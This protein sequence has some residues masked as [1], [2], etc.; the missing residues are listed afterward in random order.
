MLTKTQIQNAYLNS[1]IDSYPDANW[2]KRNEH[3]RWKE[4]EELIKYL[5]L[6]N[7]D[8]PA[9]ALPPVL[10]E[11]NQVWQQ[12]SEAFGRLCQALNLCSAENFS[13]PKNQ[14]VVNNREENAKEKARQ[15]AEIL[16]SYI[17]YFGGFDTSR[18]QYWSA[19]TYI[20]N[21]YS[22]DLNEL[23]EWLNWYGQLPKAQKSNAPKARL[24]NEVCGA[25]LA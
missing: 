13:D 14:N 15:A 17:K 10:L 3:E 7:T 5:Y 18:I 1:G 20:M 22:Y 19:A 11:L 25:L 4:I 16:A 2:M 12:Q 24:L 6:K 21:R 23:N 8:L 9:L